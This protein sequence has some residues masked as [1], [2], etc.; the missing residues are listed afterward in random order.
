M[1]GVAF[2]GEGAT[3]EIDDFGFVVEKE[4]L[5]GHAE[6][7]RGRGED[8]RHARSV[9]DTRRLAGCIGAQWCGGGKGGARG[10]KSRGLPTRKGI[11]ASSERRE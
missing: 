6:S 3:E 10:V 2:A 5:R 7:N 11:S 8:G 4:D 9:R 1:D